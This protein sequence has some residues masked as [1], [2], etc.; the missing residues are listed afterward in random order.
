MK[1]V[2]VLPY[3]DG[4]ADEYDIAIRLIESAGLLGE[5]TFSGAE[6]EC[7][8]NRDSRAA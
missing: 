3:F 5:I 4:M 1:T 2:T 7:P 8:C 6:R